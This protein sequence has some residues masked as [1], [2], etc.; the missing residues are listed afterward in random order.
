[1]YNNLTEKNMK[2]RLLGLLMMIALLPL[3][4]WAQTFVNLTPRPKTMITGTGY[5][6][7]PNKFSI[8]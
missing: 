6:N 3:G 7:L 8:Y 5:L 4:A 2:N 1:M